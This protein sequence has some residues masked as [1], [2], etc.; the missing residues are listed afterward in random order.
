[1]QRGEKEGK[2]KNKYLLMKSSLL[3]LA[4]YEIQCCSS[5]DAMETNSAIIGDTLLQC[6]KLVLLPDALE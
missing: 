2:M 4:H 1:V 5:V 6:I 3:I